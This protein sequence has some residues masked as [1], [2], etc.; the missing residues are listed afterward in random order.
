MKK[1]SRWALVA[2]AALILIALVWSG[3]NWQRIQG[4]IQA[5]SQKGYTAKQSV[6]SPAA[7]RSITTDLQDVTVVI[8]VHAADT[9]TLDY[10]ESESH[11]FAITSTNGVV[12]VKRAQAKSNQPYCLFSCIGAPTTVTISV[13]ANSRY[14]YDLTADNGHV[15]FENNGQLLAQSVRVNSSNSTV[16]LHRTITEGAITLQS[17][18]GNINVQDVTTGGKLHL[19]SSN[20]THRL[21]NVSAATIEASSANGNVRFE[22][23]TAKDVTAHA[24]NG[25]ITLAKLDAAKINLTSDNGGVDGRFVGTKDAYDIRATSENGSMRINGADHN[26]DYY[27]KTPT[28][29]R[30]LTVTSSNASVELNFEQ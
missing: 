2:G 5:I 17:N 24:S 8:K 22:G 14:A 7:I 16:V 18:N 15:R 1:V 10:S 12:S 28:A 19:E 23:V 21:T 11:T 20:G 30:T 13:P 29:S 26:G 6:I 9:I 4:D 3:F 25:R 27:A